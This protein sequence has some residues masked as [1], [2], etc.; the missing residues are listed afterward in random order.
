M[1]NLFMTGITIA[2]Q[3]GYRLVCIEDDEMVPLDFGI[4]EEY[5]GLTM[6]VMILVLIALIITIYCSICSR[7]RKR[8]RQLDQTVNPGWNLIRLREMEREVEMQKVSE[9]AEPEG[10]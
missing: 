3:I 1:K 8:I 4:R 7:Y 6:A 9:L 5:Y 2:Q 10:I